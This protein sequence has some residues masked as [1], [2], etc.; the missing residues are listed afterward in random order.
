MK[1][2][3]SVQ[4]NMALNQKRQVLF[5]GQYYALKRVFEVCSFCMLHIISLVLAICYDF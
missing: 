2:L 3:P 4:F 5:L 1:Q